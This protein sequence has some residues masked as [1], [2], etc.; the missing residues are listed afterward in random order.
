MG[1]LVDDIYDHNERLSK[2]E[3]AVASCAEALKLRSKVISRLEK[4]MK[5]FES[6]F[7]LNKA[8]IVQIENTVEAYADAY[9]ANR[10]NIQ[11]LRDRVKKVEV[12][13]G[14][15]APYDTEE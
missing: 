13:T 11:V 8:S 9:K 6:E 3:A 15:R 12:Q 1:S 5:E 4:K 10:E 2:L 14:L 7:N